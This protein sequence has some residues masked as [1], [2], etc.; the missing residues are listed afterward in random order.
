MATTQAYAQA[1]KATRA[2]GTMQ[3]TDPQHMALFCD[4][5]IQILLGAVSPQ[6]VWEGAQKSGL[7]TQELAK[8]IHDDPDAARD[9]MWL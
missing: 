5:S 4:S 9:L 1:L 2:T 7:T 3:L 8:L 6:L